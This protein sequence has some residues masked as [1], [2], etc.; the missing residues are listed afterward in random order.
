VARDLQQA[1]HFDRSA[2]VGQADAELHGPA[3]YTPRPLRATGGGRAS[4]SAGPADVDPDAEN[5]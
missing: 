2:V 5:S 1:R 4:R 3:A